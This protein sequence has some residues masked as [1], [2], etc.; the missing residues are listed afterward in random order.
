MKQSELT[1]RILPPVAAILG[2]LI[3]GS[4]LAAGS[5]SKPGISIR[6][7]WLREPNAAQRI[8]AAFLTIE[9][10]SSKDTALIEAS[11]PDAGKVEMHRMSNA[12]GMMKMEQVQRIDVPAQQTVRLKPGGL[13]L[14]L[15]DLKRQLRSGD[16][17]TLELRFA[18]GSRPTV[19]AK[20]KGPDDGA[21]S[22]GTS[23]QH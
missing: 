2:I 1:S 17:I 9:N 8:G 13:H 23:P 22:Q 5:A 10:S 11:S 18:D 19:K 14:M 12:G 4:V 21:D 20:V 3:A 7:V 15:F 16:S 6:D